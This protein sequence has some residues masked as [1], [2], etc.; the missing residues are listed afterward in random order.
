MAKVL[1]FK[2]TDKSAT[3]LQEVSRLIREANEG[4]KKTPKWEPEKIDRFNVLVGKLLDNSA[5]FV[6]CNPG[7]QPGELV[8]EMGYKL[9]LIRDVLRG[10]KKLPPMRDDILA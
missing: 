4:T 9:E 7:P 8:L 3:V 1:E 6:V 2:F 10:D 5:D